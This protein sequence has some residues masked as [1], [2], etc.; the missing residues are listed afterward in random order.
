MLSNAGILKR[1]TEEW[2]PPQP[3]PAVPSNSGPSNIAR[4]EP[5]PRRRMRHGADAEEPTQA[6][7]VGPDS[8]NYTVAVHLATSCPPTAGAQVPVHLPRAVAIAAQAPHAAISRSS[9][10][11]SP[12][13]HA[14]YR[15]RAQA[16]RSSSKAP[17]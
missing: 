17:G 9:Y 4:E 2:S 14:L 7:P 11:S 13:S 16:A 8:G 5:G 6:E 10:C 1:A 3:Q 15:P 12:C